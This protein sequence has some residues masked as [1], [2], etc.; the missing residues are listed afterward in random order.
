MDGFHLSDEVLD[1]VGL[2][3][4]KGAPETF[5]VFG[6]L[7]LLERLAR[8]GESV[9]Y[10]PKFRREFEMAEAGVVPVGP[11]DR[12]VVV[13]GNYLLLAEPPWDRVSGLLDITIYLDMDPDV[14]RG[15]LITR[16]IAHGRT[17]SE[18][19]VWIDRND[20]VNAAL[21][22]TTMGRATWICELTS[23]PRS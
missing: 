23:S 5:D 1:A 19:Q 15:R 22:E 12:L 16:H 20:E 14:R 13:E 11:A 8:S 3:D 21:V 4:R 18:A 7:T 6:F 17:R 2:A 10:A 9:I